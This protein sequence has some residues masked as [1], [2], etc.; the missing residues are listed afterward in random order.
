MR[1]ARKPSAG[2]AGHIVRRDQLEH[3]IRAA[4]DFLG[5]DTIIV[6][7]TQAILASAPLPSEVALMRSMEADLL[8]LDDPD[9]SK[10]I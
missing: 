5:E 10:A 1:Y 8:P 3:L 4:G 2:R 7:A 9:E 6:I